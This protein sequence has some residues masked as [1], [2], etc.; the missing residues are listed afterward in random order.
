MKLI[1]LI[2]QARVGK[3]TVAAH[4]AVQIAKQHFHGDF[5]TCPSK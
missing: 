3:D 4:A 2:G 5:A 1:G